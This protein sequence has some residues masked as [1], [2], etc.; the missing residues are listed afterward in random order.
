MLDVDE[1]EENANLCG[2]N[3]VCINLP[4]TFQCVC[5]PGYTG[6]SGANC[7]GKY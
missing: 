2:D 7:V 6:N 4:G 3:S 5:N 1:C